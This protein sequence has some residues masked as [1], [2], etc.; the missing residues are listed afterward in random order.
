MKLSPKQRAKRRW[1]TQRDKRAVIKRS[2]RDFYFRQTK[3]KTVF[4]TIHLMGHPLFWKN[5]V[6]A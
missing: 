1:K 5:R 3:I 2:L 4:G 6:A